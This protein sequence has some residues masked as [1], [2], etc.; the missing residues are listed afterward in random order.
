M[1]AERWFEEL[2]AWFE[3]MP[4]EAPAWRDAYQLSDLVLRLTPEELTE[5]GGRIWEIL[6]AYDPERRPEGGRPVMFMF[7][8]YPREEG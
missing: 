4:G 6:S 8:G 5:V 2:A 3:R 1:I 7:A